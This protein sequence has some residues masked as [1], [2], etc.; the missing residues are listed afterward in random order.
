M[1]WEDFKTKYHLRDADR[2]C[3][4]CKHGDVQYD[5]EC[6][7]DHPLCQ[8]SIMAGEWTH[9]VCDL[10][11]DPAPSHKSIAPTESEATHE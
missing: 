9:S 11:E 5:G 7:C 3:A 10:W 1:T 8:D 6:S 4:N 2:C